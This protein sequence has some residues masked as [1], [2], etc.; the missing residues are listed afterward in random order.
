MVRAVLADQQLLR[1]LKLMAQPVR[2]TAGAFP[3][4]VVGPPG[5]VAGGPSWRAEYT[6]AGWRDLLH[7]ETWP[8]SRSNQTFVLRH[9]AAGSE[10]VSRISSHQVTAAL[11]VRRA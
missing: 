6:P 1:C 9:G 10:S 2:L 3:Q 7:P 11:T 5:P 8:S 4:G